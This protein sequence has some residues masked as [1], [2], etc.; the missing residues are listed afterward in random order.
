MKYLILFLTLSFS[1]L[2]SGQNN[3]ANT[4]NVQVRPTADLKTIQLGKIQVSTSDVAG[5]FTV[6]DA[7]SYIE[8]NPQWRLPTIEELQL[9]YENRSK[10]SNL[11]YG[12]D[13]YLASGTQN[14]F[15]FPNSNTEY[16]RGTWY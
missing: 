4:S 3:K 13:S 12:W 10:L 14:N 6:K 9:I 11:K 16:G 8:R 7:Q 2:A 5:Y 15:K 1:L